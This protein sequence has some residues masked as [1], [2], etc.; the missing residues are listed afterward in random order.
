MPL[1]QNPHSL[2]NWAISSGVAVCSR[3]EDGEENIWII[4][5]PEGGR[6]PLQCREGEATQIVLYDRYISY[7]MRTQL[8]E[9]CAKQQDCEGRTHYCN[10]RTAKCEPIT[11]ASPIIE[12]AVVPQTPTEDVFFLG[13]QTRVECLQGYVYLPNRGQAR[14]DGTVVCQTPHLV[15]SG[16][17][18]WVD[19]NTLQPP[20]CLEGCVDCRDCGP[21]TAC[22]FDGHC[23][24]LRCPQKELDGKLSLRCTQGDKEKD[25]VGQTCRYRTP[26]G[27]IVKLL[28]EVRTWHLLLL[29]CS[30]CNYS[31][32]C[33]GHWHDHWIHS[34]RHHLLR[35][36]L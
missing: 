11:C 4:H 31:S 7:L 24:S 1:L 3:T 18:L 22:S 35:E 20:K 17:G 16:Q 15:E 29:A 8:S 5:L 26:P 30:L 19:V 9:G 13:Q 14:R 34:C 27:Y 6:V 32:V 33:A 23:G 12:G 25:E 36:S 2:V 10:R 21:N 28:D